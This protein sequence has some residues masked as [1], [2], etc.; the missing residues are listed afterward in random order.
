MYQCNRLVRNKISGLFPTYFGRWDFLFLDT[1][2]V[3][4]MIRILLKY[5]LL[6]YS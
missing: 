5:N 4:D 1:I 3:R 2:I 6:K